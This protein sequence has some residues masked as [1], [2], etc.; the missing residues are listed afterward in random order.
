MNR[1]HYQQLVPQPVEKV[2]PFFADEKNLETITPPW[3]NFKVLGKSTP[4]L[5]SGTLINYKLAV[6]GIPLK[7]QSVI[8]D[9]VPNEKFVDRQIVGPYSHWHHTHTFEPH[10]QGTL[11]TDIIEYRVPGGAIGELLGG[12]YV[13]RDLEKIFAYRRKTIEKLFP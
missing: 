11:M 12:W 9:W 4:R 2:F 1:L 3:L 5:Q 8:E 7:W 6:R 10:P 13:R